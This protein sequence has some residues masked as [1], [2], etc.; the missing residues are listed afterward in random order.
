LFSSA[1]EVSTAALVVCAQFFHFL[2]SDDYICAAGTGESSKGINS[3][4]SLNVKKVV[5]V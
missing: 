5:N 4:I 3:R 1:T 2:L